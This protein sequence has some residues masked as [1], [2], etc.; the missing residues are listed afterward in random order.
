MTTCDNDTINL[1]ALEPDDLDL[2]F[3]VENDASLWSIGNTNVP[4]SRQILRNYIMNVTGDIYTDKQ[5]RM[6]VE[7]IDGP[8]EAEGTWATIGIVDLIDFDPRNSRAEVGIVILG[9]F[10]RQGY[11]TRVINQ[12]A[13][14]ART[15]L[16][17]HQLYAFIRVDNAASRALFR[18]CRFSELAELDDWLYDGESY[19]KA[20]L[21]QKIL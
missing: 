5:L 19:Q 4:Y 7:R 8:G 9:Q 10:R 3:N 20:V 16:R 17:I 11:A 13:E 12:L 15:I 1:R 18:R 6:I 21:A 2:L 14:Y